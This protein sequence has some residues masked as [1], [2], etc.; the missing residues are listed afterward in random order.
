M[1]WERFTQ[2][3]SEVS[4]GRGHSDTRGGVP[5]GGNLSKEEEKFLRAGGT[6]NGEGSLP[7]GGIIQRGLRFLREGVT[8]K[9]RGS[10]FERGSLNVGKSFIPEG[11]VVEERGRFPRER[12]S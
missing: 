6:H 5:S 1:V 9:G 10:S 4:F 2:K 3:G 7:S 8:Q 11:V 12:Y